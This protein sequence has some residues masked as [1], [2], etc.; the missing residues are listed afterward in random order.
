MELCQG[1]GSW[2]S[3]EGSA[4]EGGQAWNRLPRTVVM[5]PSCQSSRSVWTT[6]SDVGFGFWVVLCGAGGWT[7][8]SHAILFT[9]VQFK[10]FCD[11]MILGRKVLPR[12]NMEAKIGASP[13]NIFTW[14]QL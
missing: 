13:L 6:L 4:P 14:K 12:L 2:V 7:W 9:K 8:K 5:A 10:L 11:S 1:R 3:G